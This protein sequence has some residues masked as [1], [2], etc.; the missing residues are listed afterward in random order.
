MQL[1]W[2]WNLITSCG[3][4]TQPI[5]MSTLPTLEH[6]V[7]F[8]VA[9]R[10]L[11]HLLQRFDKT[12]CVRLSVGVGSIEPRR[13]FVNIFVSFYLDPLYFLSL[14]SHIS[15]QSPLKWLACWM[16]HQTDERQVLSIL[17]YGAGSVIFWS[18]EFE[19][20][21]SYACSVHAH[22]HTVCC[23]HR[24]GMVNIPWRR[25]RKI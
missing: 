4:F 25:W 9:Q 13:I 2:C 21:Q 20:F 22:M 15:S 17:K 6:S 5:Q 7:G 1:K 12:W 18:L 14:N 16:C 3:Q 19:K 11:I 10:V 24:Y 23:Y 8:Q